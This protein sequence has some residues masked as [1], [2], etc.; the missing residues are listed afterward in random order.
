MILQALYEYSERKA[1]E[2]APEGFEFKEIPFLCV[3]DS[4]GGFIGFEDTR[5]QEGN[6][7]RGKIFLVPALGEMKG[8]GIKANL[9]WENIE[10]MFGISSK[11]KGDP[12]RVAAQ[13]AAFKEKIRMHVPDPSVSPWNLVLSFLESVPVDLLKKDPLWPEVGQPT[14]LVLLA[15]DGI[16]P[17]TAHPDI[18]NGPQLGD[19]S[20]SGQIEGLCLVSGKKTVIAKLLPP[21]K[22]VRDSNPTGASLVAINNVIKNGR[23]QNK[24]PAFASFM[25]EKGY[26]SPIGIREAEGFAKA[27][28]HM[29]RR[30]SPNKIQIGDA[31]TVFWSEKETVFEKKYSFFFSMPS[32]DDPDKGLLEMRAAIES[33]KSGIPPSESS[34]RF[35]VLGLAPNSARIAVRFWHQGTVGEF[36][37]NILRHFE[38]L[39]IITP[40][41]DKGNLSLSNLLAATVLDWKS[42][43]VPPN[44]AGNVMRAVMTGGTYPTT[45]FQQC[46]RRI[47]SEQGKVNTIRASILK[48]CLNRRV[49]YAGH[50]PEKEMTVALDMENMNVGYRLGRLFAILEKI[51]EDANPG[52]NA[53]IRDR[54]YGAASTTPVSVFPRLLKL[55][56]HHLAKLEN[57]AFRVI[58]E[59]R[60]AEVIGGLGTSMPSHLSMDDQARF[61]LGYYHQRQAFFNPNKEN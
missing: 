53:T 57:T 6:K 43:N 1:T 36:A 28:N 14:S 52:I 5:Q 11:E 4:R 45:L 21:I 34:S 32:K 56:N 13:A 35:Y 22:G 46:L 7:K 47:R 44:L 3:L 19:E 24:T 48:A 10:Y 39:E 29:L 50:D 30:D 27:L 37:S 38:D 16:G 59:K 12:K 61:A 2:L 54:F 42:E 58:H 40:S 55:K 31:T 51:Q 17:L 15:M 8:N 25:K 23:N 41:F 33:I 60:L 26:N 9:L 20:D 49:R 18:L